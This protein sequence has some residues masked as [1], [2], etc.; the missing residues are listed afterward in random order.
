MLKVFSD[1]KY[2]L[3]GSTCHMLLPFWSQAAPAENDP[4][5]GRFDSYVRNGDSLFSMVPVEEADIVVYPSPP[6]PNR[7]PF[8][9]FQMVTG[10]KPLAVFFNSDVDSTVSGR[11][12]TFVF[13]TSFYRSSRLAQEFALP[14]WSADPG[15]FPPRK[16]VSRPTVGFC[17]VPDRFG[18]R[19]SGMCAL[20]SCP[21]VVTRFIRR[22]SFWGVWAGKTG[23]Q[24]LLERREFLSNMGDSDYVLCARGGGNFS[25]RLYE[26]MACGRIPLLIDTDCVLPYDFLIDWSAMFPIVPASDIKNIGSRLL[27]FHN[28]FGDHPEAFEERQILI[29]KMWEEY[30]SPLGFFTNLHRHLEV[31]K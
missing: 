11:A 17:G 18:I 16:W 31:T 22:C 4:D 6:L 9:E 26:T 15:A 29:R 2:L 14:A 8:E 13:R 19:E 20:E 5:A 12:G 21:D 24:H 28:A 25:Y 23:N 27:E 10:D 3:P 7:L 30:I 1:R